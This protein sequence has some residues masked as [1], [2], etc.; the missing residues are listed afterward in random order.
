[1]HAP[2]IVMNSTGNGSSAS[3]IRLS[4]CIATYGRA[5][6]I[7][8]T[9]KCILAQV[10]GGVEIVVVDGASPDN[11]SAVVGQLLTA[12]PCLRYQREGANAGVDRDFDK[13]VSYARGDYCWLMSDDDLLIPG[14]VPTVMEWLSDEPDL[15]VVNAEVRSK[16][17]SVV[18][19]PKQLQISR[20]VEFVSG[21]IENFF[22]LAAPY[23][24]F[25]GGVVIRRETWLSRCR[26]P[27]Y[28]SLFIHMGVIFQRPALGR[29]KL[30]ARPLI[31]IRYGN[32]LWTSRGY[33][34]WTGMWPRLIWA[35]DH[36]SIESRR[37]VSIECP[38]RR[39]RTLLWYR[40]VGAYG[41]AQYRQTPGNSAGTHLLAPLIAVLP[42]GLLNVLLALHC[43]AS[44]HPDASMKLYDLARAQRASW[45]TRWLA[46][47]FR[48]PEMEK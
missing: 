1:M 4:I 23:L 34:I 2:Q 45:L 19:K 9:L 11:T 40:A 21:D 16:D 8:D 33:E 38:S 18:L 41:L 47:R 36:F 37:Q 29:V 39:L 42:A 44:S 7:G 27:Y 14:A 43:V 48:F 13:A 30:M 12:N 28:G 32:A 26:Q 5:D 35:F 17:L 22:V 10:P 3:R 31:Q 15:L 20:D 25:I 46:R 24:S 6:F